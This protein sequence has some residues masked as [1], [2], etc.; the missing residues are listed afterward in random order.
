[1]SPAGDAVVGF[2]FASLTETVSRPHGATVWAGPSKLAEGGSP[3]AV[4]LDGAGNA[5][6]VFTKGQWPSQHFQ[7]SYRSRAVGDWQDPITVSPAEQTTGGDIAVN[8]S[9]DAVA[10]FTRW[11]GT[12]YVIQAAVR[13]AASGRWEDV[14]DLS[15][16]SGNSPNG[17]GVAIDKAGNALALWVRAGRVAE[18]PVVVSAFRPA[19][20]TWTTPV[21]LGGPYGE[22]WDMNVAFDTAGNAVAVWRGYVRS[23][24]GYVVFSSYR[25]FG[26]SWTAAASLSP[27]NQLL[28]DDLALTVDARGNALALWREVTQGRQSVVIADSRPAATGRWEPIEQLSPSLLFATAAA[29]T[30][31]RSGN[32]VAVWTEGLGDATVHATLRPAAS[33]AWER[34]V[35][36]ASGVFGGDVAVAMDESGNAVAAWEREIGNRFTI[37]ISDLEAGGPVLAQLEVPERAAAGVTARFH[38]TPSAWGSP[39]VG[40]PVWDFGDGGSARGARVTH[41]YRRTGSYRVA[42]TQSDAAGGSSG[43]TATIVVGR[44]T[45]ANR[46]R[47]AIVGVPRVGATLTCL[48]GSWRGSQPIRFRYAWLRGGSQVGSGSRYRVRTSDA[49]A[50][51]SCRVTATNGARTVAAVSRRVR[52]R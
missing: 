45:L 46:R 32:A 6:A 19:G 20:G 3:P 12:G 37:E 1:M 43:S 14:V 8:A 21:E 40:E 7:A 47:P 22:V 25:P 10:A 33:K 29:L 38:V 26:G 18:D 24:G 23:S 13:P 11:P 4:A 17:A 48:S 50:L 49:G 31:D 42:V 52:I 9:G 27:G 28:V 41:T 34:P 15:D 30:S 5:Y 39:L 51:V 2:A 36:I 44:A 16:P 35:Q